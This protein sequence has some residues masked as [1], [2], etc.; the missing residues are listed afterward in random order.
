[1]GV[2]NYESAE[3]SAER[4]TSAEPSRS[5]EVRANTGTNANVTAGANTGSIARD[6][7]PH[8]ATALA[9]FFDEWGVDASLE[10]PGATPTSCAA[11]GAAHNNVSAD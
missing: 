7:A 1:L 4:S 6:G 3:S 10:S 11:T 9:S 8:D 5:A 2:E